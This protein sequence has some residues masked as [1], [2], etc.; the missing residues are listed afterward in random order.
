MLYARQSL[1]HQGR[2]GNQS[3]EVGIWE[4]VADYFCNPL[5]AP[6]GDEPV[7]NDRYP[8]RELLR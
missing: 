1:W 4:Y 2:I 8:H 6:L 5:S 7:M 3:E